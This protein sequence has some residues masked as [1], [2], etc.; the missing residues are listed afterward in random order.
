MDY[1]SYLNEKLSKVLF[2]SIKKQV[3]FNTFKENVEEDFYLPIISSEIIDKAEDI[4]KLNTIP[5]GVFIEAMFYVVGLDEQFKY[6]KIYKKLLNSSEN[7]VKFIKGKIFNYINNNN[8]ELAYFLLKGLNSIEESKDYCEKL[9]SLAEE[10]RKINNMFKEEELRI[11]EK[12][13]KIDGS[14][15]AYLYEAIIY[16][17]EEDYSK[18]IMALN[19]FI[20]KG[21]KETE[22]IIEFKN[23]LNISLK[24][25]KGKELI[26]L[27][28]EKAL[29]LL[30]PLMEYMEDN[31]AL[32]YNIAICYRMI[33]NH[34]KSIYYLN[35][36]LRLDPDYIDVINELGINYACIGVYDRAIKYLRIAFEATKA[37]E[38]CT[39]LVMC[40][41]NS[42]DENQAKLHLDLANKLDPSD[43]IVKQLN[44]IIK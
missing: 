43:E 26:N 39:N 5:A 6:N 2:I 16:N 40:Y 11:I 15:K 9:L 42:G 31:V 23:S 38:I 41:M 30:L 33:K 18:A 28:P 35:D 10:L 21:G 36:A 13:K 20:S 19:E 7:N 24:Y 1:I 44:E 25:S 12:S 27:D 32:L 29:Q 37:V 3:I 22:D 8:L 14:S 34:E 4:V 17:E